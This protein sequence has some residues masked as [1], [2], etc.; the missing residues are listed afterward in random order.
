MAS[1]NN[2]HNEWAGRDNL[3]FVTV[4]WPGTESEQ[5]VIGGVTDKQILILGYI[6]A[7]DSAGAAASWQLSSD[8]IPMCG[9]TSLKNFGNIT[10]PSHKDGV[11]LGEDSAGVDITTTGLGSVTLVYCCV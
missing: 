8:S 2:I 3:Q 5:E 4:S 6:V 9:V 11:M 7:A 1:H 10:S